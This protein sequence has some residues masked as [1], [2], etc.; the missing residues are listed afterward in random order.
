MLI[1]EALA[2]QQGLAVPVEMDP[3]DQPDHAGDAGLADDRL[4]QSTMSQGDGSTVLDAKV[5]RR[6]LQQ[7]VELLQNRVERLRQEERKAKQKVLETKIRG[8]E[9][10][11]LQKRNEQAAQAKELAKK[12]NTMRAQGTVWPLR[13]QGVRCRLHQ[14]STWWM[15]AMMILT[16]Y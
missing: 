13:H 7:D 5:A 1:V 10:K 16:E 8:Q 15:S 6:K 11:A 4:G 14:A 12:M 2:L 3:P 9:I